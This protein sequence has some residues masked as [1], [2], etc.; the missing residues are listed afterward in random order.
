MCIEIGVK[1]FYGENSI[2]FW[3]AKFYNSY[4]VAFLLQCNNLSSL[5]S[6][7]IKNNDLSL[8][9]KGF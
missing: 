1:I 3:K 8:W 9:K 6:P 4:V 5:A 7:L 2:P